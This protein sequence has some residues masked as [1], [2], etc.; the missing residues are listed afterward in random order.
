MHHARVECRHIV[1]DVAEHIDIV[2]AG[3]YMLTHRT[4]ALCVMTLSTLTLCVLTFD[5]LTHCPMASCAMTLSTLTL[6]VLTLNAL[7]PQPRCTVGWSG[8]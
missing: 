7:M 5:M 8:L 4:M 1:L 6:C 3:V 2:R